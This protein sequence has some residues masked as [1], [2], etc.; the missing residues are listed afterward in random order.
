M[1]TGIRVLL[2]TVALAVLPGCATVRSCSTME[3]GPTAATDTSATT[4]RERR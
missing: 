4:D 2:L 3:Q 1:E